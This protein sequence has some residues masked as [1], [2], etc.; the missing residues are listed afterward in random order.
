VPSFRAAYLIHG[1]D[2]GRI[3]E[4]RAR[5]RA[6]AEDA[7]GTAGV[8]V[9]EADACTP[10]AVAAALSTMTFAMG[11]RFVIA[12]GVERWKEGDVDA[13]AAALKSADPES[14][15]VAFFAR[16]EAR[17]KAPAKLRKA[18]EAVGGQIAEEATVKP[19]ELPKWLVKQAAQLELELDPEA[20]KVLIAQVGDRQQR[21]LRELEKLAL[22]RG[23]QA[24]LGVEEIQEA[25]ASSAERKVWT[26]TDA[27]V[28]GDRRTATRV[29]LELRTQGERLP[30]MTYTIAR[31]LREALAVAEALAAGQSPA[32]AKKS[33]RMSPRQASKLVADV[34]RRDADAFR[35]ALAALADFEL[36][37]RGGVGG[38]GG[39]GE[40]TAALKAVLTA[41]R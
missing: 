39:L 11:R 19:W 2:H 17:A 40:E 33:L 30:A 13:I 41:T 22:E 28:A 6:M 29:L 9:Y 23:A 10:D 16:E 4:R 7:A 1:D 21:L 5:L 26:L 18:V 31:K 8:E 25:C 27:M 35:R 20:A 38:R 3:S 36:E 32:Q 24:R 15:T 14:L 12:D 34:E 37:S